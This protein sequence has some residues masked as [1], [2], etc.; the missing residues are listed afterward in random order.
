MHRTRCT[1]AHPARCSWS[2]AVHR[3]SGRPPGQPMTHMNPHQQERM[4]TCGVVCVCGGRTG[5]RTCRWDRAVPTPRRR[6]K[7]KTLAS[8]SRTRTSS[9][10]C[11]ADSRSL[12]TNTCPGTPVSASSQPHALAKCRSKNRRMLLSCV[13]TRRSCGGS[14][15]LRKVVVEPSQRSSEAPRLCRTRPQHTQR[16][17]GHQPLCRRYRCRC[18]PGCAPRRHGLDAPPP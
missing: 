15:H 10:R 6:C 4:H 2:P 16:C 8:H 5:G 3:H 11:T 9:A 7:S 18:A 14:P 13:S 17:T 12:R 1:A